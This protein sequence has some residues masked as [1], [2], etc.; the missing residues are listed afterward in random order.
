MKLNNGLE[1]LNTALT[2]AILKEYVSGKKILLTLSGGMDTR[3]ILAIML[4]HGIIPDVMTWDGSPGDIKIAHTISKKYGL[5]H[6]LVHKKTDDLNWKEDVNKVLKNYDIIY[7]GELMSE[8]FNK[9]VRF[10]E[11]E[12]KLNNLITNFY[13]WVEYNVDREKCNKIM[14]CLDKKVMEATEKIPIC[15]RVYG[16]INRKL[17]QYNYPDLMKIPHTVVNLRYRV[18]ECFYWVV[19]PLIGRCA[20]Y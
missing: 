18:L 4:K 2:D 10:T 14:P 7:Y 20:K 12:K 8:V 6:I 11:S 9:F 15:F 19:I 13:V 5:N 16:Y 3:L 1:Q 17:I